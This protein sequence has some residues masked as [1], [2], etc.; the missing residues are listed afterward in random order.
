MHMHVYN[1]LFP[2][3]KQH[4][5]KN[6]SLLSLLSHVRLVLIVGPDDIR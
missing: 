2:T 3:C 1:Y 4:Q 5:Y 6:L